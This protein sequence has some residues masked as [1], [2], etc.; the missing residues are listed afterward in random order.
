[1]GRGAELAAPPLAMRILGGQPLRCIEPGWLRLAF[2][3]LLL[4]TACTSQDATGPGGDRARPAF[5]RYFRDP[6]PEF[7]VSPTGSPSG[8]GSFD[9]PWDL[10]TALSGPATVT[11]GST[12]WLRGGTYADGPSLGGYESNL[13]G[14]PTAPIVV[15]QYPDEHATVTKFLVVLGAYTWYWGFEVVHT[16]PPVGS[17]FFGIDDHGPGVKF[18][19]LVVHDATG[20]GIFIQPEATD[21][22]VYGSIVYNNGRTDN[23]DHGIYCQ[24]QSSLLVQDNIVFDNWAFGIHCFD[25]PVPA[26]HNITLE[27]NVAFNDYIWGGTSDAD[28]FVGGHFPATG[29]I[30]DQNYTYRTND[31]NTK[32]AD[33]GYNLVVNNDLVLSDNYFVGGWLHLG[34]WA[35]ATVSGNTFFNFTHGGMVWNFGDVSGQTWSGNT[36]FGDSS[37]LEWRHDSSTVSTFADW[38]TLTG[39][40]DPGS[41]AG[42][43]PAGLN[44]VV[45]PNA[46]EPGRAN[47]IV[48]NWA[49][50]GT[51]SVDVSGILHAGDRYVVQNAQDFYGAPVAGGIYSGGSLQLSMVGVTPPIPLGTT[52]VQAAPVTGPTFNV[53]VLM[54]TSH[55]ACVVAERGASE[56]RGESEG[57]GPPR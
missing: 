43:S 10:A 40:A 47:I 5:A 14:T 50:Q 33:I 30:I 52:P 16:L 53:F 29:I 55:G 36:F 19:N 42:T 45:R 21:A 22:E 6:P 23:L 39:L 56:E 46:Y 20:S 9:N 27:G 57:C 11:P 17:Q 34:A 31:S 24:S 8:D 49:Q 38:R 25:K 41:Y 1:M 12:I 51:V 2:A 44:V 54:T 48:Y 37:A 32:A 3:S 28:I 35:T 7:Y 18:I 4:W 15:R 26:L 13:T